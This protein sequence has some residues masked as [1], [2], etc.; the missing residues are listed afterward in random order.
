[1]SSQNFPNGSRFTFYT[2]FAKV[3]PVIGRAFPLP[4]MRVVIPAAG[5]CA[6]HTR[7]RG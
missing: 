4:P 5:G 6:L 2:W 1:M 7:L 3:A